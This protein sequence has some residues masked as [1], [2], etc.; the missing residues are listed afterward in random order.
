MQRLYR[1]VQEALTNATT[2]AKANQ[3]GV[4]VSCLEGVISTSIRT[5]AGGSTLG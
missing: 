4:V 3:V 5:T 2:Y 1:D